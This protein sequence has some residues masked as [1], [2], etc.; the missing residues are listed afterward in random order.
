MAGRIAALVTSGVDSVEVQDEGADEL[1]LRVGPNEK[2]ITAI[3]ES[4]E[5]RAE[6]M[7]LPVPG[8]QQALEGQ[9]RQLTGEEEGRL[10][11]STVDRAQRC[12]AV[13][14]DSGKH[15][16]VVVHPGQ[17]QRVWGVVVG[18]GIAERR[19][20][21]HGYGHEAIMPG[22][23]AASYPFCDASACPSTAPKGGPCL[24]VQGRPK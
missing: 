17:A 24:T 6:I 13:F 18:R 19:L 15:R 1:L 9:L 10:G 3:L 5:Q 22:R 8:P 14:I 7:A 16:R 23:F 21:H 11:I 20:V 2:I 12:P 4:L